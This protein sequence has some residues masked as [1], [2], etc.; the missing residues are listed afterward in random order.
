LH[1]EFQKCCDT[2][3]MSFGNDGAPFDRNLDHFMKVMMVELSKMIL[4]ISNA[5][6]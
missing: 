3:G 2:S 4:E 1:F 5:L 6:D